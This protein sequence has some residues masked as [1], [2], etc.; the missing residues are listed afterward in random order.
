M[1][2]FEGKVAVITGGARGIG[3]GIARAF[4]AE[5]MRVLLGDI[6]AATVEAAADELRQGGAQ[7]HGVAVDVRDAESVE[8][9]VAASQEHF[10]GADVVVNNAGVYLGGPMSG[11]TFDDW[12]FVLDVNLDGMFRVGQRFAQLLREQGRGGHVVN[13]ASIGGF[14]SHGEGVAYAVSKYGVVAYSEALRGELE[15][16]GIGV[17]TLCPGP[18]DTELP[19][20][21]RLRSA[22]DQS[23]AVSEALAPFIRDGMK[24]DDVG[25]IVVRGIRKNLAYIFTH[26]DMRE[27]FATRFQNVLN[28]MDEIS[29]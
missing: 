7:A 23:G 18:I 12:R 15:P 10:G 21:D 27:L 20:S 14:L 25:P 6:D 17:S 28:A 24:P 8:A 19:A 22:S 3:L 2:H 16:H 11:L 5:G 26:D 4:A 13:T 29:G 9:L 1:E